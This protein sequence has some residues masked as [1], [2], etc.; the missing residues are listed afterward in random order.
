ML[1]GQAAIPHLVFL[2][3]LLGL[4]S[5]NAP[6]Q[7]SLRVFQLYTHV[8]LSYGLLIFLGGFIFSY[9]HKLEEVFQVR[10]RRK[11]DC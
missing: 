10:E 8:Q 9:Y 2:Q 6:R 4:T 1:E 5:D 3:L 11:D 7:E